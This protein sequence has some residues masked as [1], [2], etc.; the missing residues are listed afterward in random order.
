ME[1]VVTIGGDLAKN[2]FRSHGARGTDPPRSAGSRPGK[3][4]RLSRRGTGPRC[5]AAG[6]GA[7]GGIRPIGP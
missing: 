2:D 4:A 3:G 7:T 5:R 1:K 6:G